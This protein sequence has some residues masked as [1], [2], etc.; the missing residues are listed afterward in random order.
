MRYKTALEIYDEEVAS[1]QMMLPIAAMSSKEKIYFD[2]L[3]NRISSLAEILNT[4]SPFWQ[5]FMFSSR[6]EYKTDSEEFRDFLTFWA[7]DVSMIKSG[8]FCRVDGEA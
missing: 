6:R 1:K 7:F 5:F 8:K 4:N 2:M 3:A